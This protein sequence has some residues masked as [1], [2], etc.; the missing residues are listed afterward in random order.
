MISSVLFLPVA[1][2]WSMLCTHW[3]QGW[4]TF[5]FVEKW[6]DIHLIFISNENKNLPVYVALSIKWNHLGSVTWVSVVLCRP[7]GRL[8]RYSGAPCLV[9]GAGLSALVQLACS[10]YFLFSCAQ[11]F[12]VPMFSCQLFGFHPLCACSYC[13]G[14]HTG[15]F[16]HTGD[17]WNKNDISWKV[18]YCMKYIYH[19]FFFVF[20]LSKHCG[21]L[22]VCVHERKILVAL[23][24]E[25]W[26]GSN[27]LLCEWTTTRPVPDQFALFYLF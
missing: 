21:S 14:Y 17:G 3:R 6:D 20:L 27:Y 24:F 9:A 25:S 23:S 2:I 5:A 26:M 7:P 15:G 13:T 19:F 10:L 16:M 11:S 18:I 12:L 8:L 22:R 1:L 4:W